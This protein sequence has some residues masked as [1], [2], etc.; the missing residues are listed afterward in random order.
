MIAGKN[1]L[2]SHA[3]VKRPPTGPVTENKNIELSPAKDAKETAGLKNMYNTYKDAAEN[4]TAQGQEHFR[5][6]QYDDALKMFS[7]AMDSYKTVHSERHPNVAQCYNNIGNVYKAMGRFEVALVKYEEALRIL[8]I[9]FGDENAN[10][11]ISLTNIGN[12]HYGMGRFEE[13][14]VMY[15]EAY[16]LKKDPKILNAIQDSKR[17]IGSGCC[18]C[19]VS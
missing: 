11:A 14:L 8:K 5:K 2:K 12:V 1:V 10:L 7:A 13:A 17:Q 16:R 9:A 19:T 4:F 6:G 18:G 15:E 3:S